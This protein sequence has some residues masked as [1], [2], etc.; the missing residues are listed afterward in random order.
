MACC[1]IAGP[2]ALPPM[3]STT[4][5]SNFSRTLAAVALMSEMTSA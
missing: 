3:P 2:S 4:K 5:A 1:T